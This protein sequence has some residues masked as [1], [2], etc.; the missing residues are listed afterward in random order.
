MK[1]GNALVDVS[2]SCRYLVASANG[3]GGSTASSKRPRFW[4]E[5][6]GQLHDRVLVL[7]ARSQEILACPGYDTCGGI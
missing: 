5:L 1:F 2:S 6:D 7:L 4:G 3:G